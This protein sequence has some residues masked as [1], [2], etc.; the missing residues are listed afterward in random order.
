VIRAQ[1]IYM[2]NMLVDSD[3]LTI[4]LYNVGSTVRDRVAAPQGIAAAPEQ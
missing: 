2:S 3:K 1:L 4:G